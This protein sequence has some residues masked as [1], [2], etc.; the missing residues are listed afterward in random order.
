MVIPLVLPE[1]VVGQEQGQH[2]R[3]ARDHGRQCH[4]EGC[5]EHMEALR[6]H[7]VR[8]P[9]TLHKRPRIR[10]LR[11]RRR[12]GGLLEHDALVAAAAHVGARDVCGAL[13]GKGA[14]AE[15]C[16]APHCG[17]RQ[18]HAAVRDVAAGLDAHSLPPV[19]RVRGQEQAPAAEDHVIAKLD[20][21]RLHEFEAA[22]RPVDV[23]ADLDAQHPVQEGNR[24]VVS[25][26]QL[27][28]AAQMGVGDHPAQEPS[29]EELPLRSVGLLAFGRL[30]KGSDQDALCKD[31]ARQRKQRADDLP[32]EHA[33][34]VKK[35]ALW[36]RE[37][38]QDVLQGHHVVFVP[39]L[40]CHLVH[41]I[42]HR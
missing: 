28:D 3:Q 15:Q 6:Q 22:S 16:A 10:A 17:A 4:A 24:L 30:G 9:A 40:Q 13:L 19:R 32:G 2:Q 18:Q 21:V 42:Q 31:G 23:L 26:Q 20:Q 27:R 8:H 39:I 33:A 29:S 34:D 7:K 25:A 14:G 11:R 37:V 38:V 12:G 41:R 5:P 35:H 1:V 36:R